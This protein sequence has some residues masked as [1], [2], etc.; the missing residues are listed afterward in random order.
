M[1]KTLFPSDKLDGTLFAFAAIFGDSI[2]L[3]HVND[4]DPLFDEIIP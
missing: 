3:H 1:P 4:I 2:Y